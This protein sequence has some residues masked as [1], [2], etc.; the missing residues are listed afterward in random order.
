MLQELSIVNL[1][2]IQSANIPLAEG[3]N[4]FTGE[5]GAGKSSLIHGIQAV[6]GQRTSKDLVRTGCKKATISA[7]F[8]PVSGETKHL[9]TDA[10][11]NLIV[12]YV[13]AFRHLKPLPGVVDDIKSTILRN[14]MDCTFELDKYLETVPF[15]YDYLRK[16]CKREMGITPHAFLTGLRMQMAEKLL[17][18][19]GLIELN[20]SEIAYNCGYSDA[21]YFSRVFKKNFGCSPKQYALSHRKKK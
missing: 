2:V 9:L 15:T 3:F 5:T 8:A 10:L 11:G 21:L 16:L 7:V 12:N 1:A 20:I 18:S 17:C 6:L 14:F 13:A 4:A 19:S